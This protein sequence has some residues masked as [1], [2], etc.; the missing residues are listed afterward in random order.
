MT[1]LRRRRRCSRIRNNS[2][3]QNKKE[4]RTMICVGVNK[5]TRIRVHEK[6]VHYLMSILTR[7]LTTL[8]HFFFSKA[9]VFIVVF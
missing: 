2:I 8:S 1:V 6:K 5:T 4:M 7:D 9:K 3:Q